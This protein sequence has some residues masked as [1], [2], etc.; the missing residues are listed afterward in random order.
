M[1]SQ[2]LAFLRDLTTVNTAPRLSLPPPPPSWTRGPSTKPPSLSFTRIS[3]Y[4]LRYSTKKSA[5]SDA[6]LLLFFRSASCQYSFFQKPHSRRESTTNL[7][8]FFYGGIGPPQQRR[9]S[10][11]I[12]IAKRGVSLSLSVSLFVQ[13][14]SSTSMMIALKYRTERSTD[15]PPKHT[16][17]LA[18]SRPDRN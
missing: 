12:P 8:E 10:I 15:R 5:L 6:R 17:T 13:S 3:L 16:H 11:Q 2:N 4:A 9:C 1:F 7:G 18:L 14:S